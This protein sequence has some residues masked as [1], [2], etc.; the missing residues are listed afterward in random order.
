[1]K[2]TQECDVCQT[3]R[4]NRCCIIEGNERNIER[5]QSEAF[6][7][8]PFVHPYRAPT[9]HAQHLR[10]MAFAKRNNRRVLWVTAFDMVMNTDHSWKSE[11]GQQRKEKWLECHERKTNGIPGLLPL[12]LD[13]PVRFTDAPNPTAREQGIFKHARGILRGWKLEEEEQARVE[14]QAD[15]SEIVLQRRPSQLFIEV[16]TANSKLALTNGEKIFVLS[17]CCITI[18]NLCK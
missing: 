16:P 12:V 18:V 2:Q 17:T 10:S 14:Q 13:L 8:A 7:D 4:R 11:K 5:Y 15:A 9:Y 6:A 1:M 3:H